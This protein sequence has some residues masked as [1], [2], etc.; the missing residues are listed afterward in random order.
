MLRSLN[1]SNFA[2]FEN[3]S[4]NFDYGFNVFTGETGS[5]KSVLINAIQLILGERA[6]KDLI[7]KGK[8]SA[9][10]E[11]IFDIGDND[12][13]YIVLDR[14]NIEIDK[15]DFLIISRELLDN[16]KSINKVNG[17]TV[18]LNTIKAMGSSL[19][20]IYGQFGHESLFKKEN[21]IKLLDSLIQKELSPILQAY[22]DLF[23]NY[24]RVQKE[25]NI[26]KEKLLNK[27]KKIEQLK[28]EINEIDTAQLKDFEEEELLKKIRKLSNVQ[29]IKN[30]LYEA[31]HILNSDSLNS[32]YTIINKI[33]SYDE[34][35]ENF[36]SRLDIQLEELKLLSYDLRDYSDKLDIDEKELD[37]IE[38]RMSFINRLKRKYGFSIEKINEYRNKSNE[39]LNLLLQADSRLNSLVMEKNEIYK[40]LTEKAVIISKKRVKVAEILE[41]QILV[42]LNDLN[43]KN[44]KF[45]VSIQ[46][47]DLSSDGIDNVEFLISTNLG[48]DLNSV[49]KIVSGGE[50]SRIML[51]FKKIK[52]D[53]GQTMIFD[54]IDTGISG[55]TAQM[56]GV[57]MNY[58][59]V[60]NQVICV[61]HSPQ[62]ASISKNHF[63]I[64]KKV[65]GNNTYST[66]R[67]L[68]KENKIYEIA[69]L[70]SG[71]KI[72]DKSLNN[73]KELIEFNSKITE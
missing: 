6:S 17:R 73:A 32:V 63:L 22:N 53:I 40:L 11:G 55:K 21:H 58:I 60:N 20:D 7:R 29:E 54:E 70:L 31:I 5:G 66:V 68:D 69:R 46:K 15:D 33:Q 44:I 13:F 72:T 56:S 62:I 67:K 28:Y 59:A 43:M 41:K 25:I 19:I 51:A 2:V 39:E 4:V 64:E 9:L 45:K 16:G 35:L 61:T 14:L 42:E 34:K 36:L 24:N 50:A 3:V 65:V 12:N 38:N 30:Y 48:S 18:P 1:I 27:D 8:N 57:K 23:V 49:Q 52:S 47:K 26:L 10:I 37:N 71:M